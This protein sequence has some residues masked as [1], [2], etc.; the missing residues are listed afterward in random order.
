MDF[1]V[2]LPTYNNLDLARQ[3]ALSVLSQSSYSYELIIVDDSSKGDI[4]KFAHE[5]DDARVRYYHNASPLGAVSNWNHG[6]NM[7]TGDFVILLHHDER[8]SNP[9]HLEKIKELMAQGCDVAISPV[10]VFIGDERHTN[11]FQRERVRAFMI[12]HPLLLFC[13]NAIGPT[14]C[15]C[16]R[17]SSLAAFNEELHWLVDVQWYYELL[18]GRIVSLLGSDYPI[19]SRHGHG[20]QITNLINVYKTQAED[21]AV[22]RKLYKNNIRIRIALF[23]N[24]AMLQIRKLARK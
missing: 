13:A 17:K 21:S 5:L 2:V 10:S 24:K 12:R 18:K 22:I 3:A 11:I 15:V 6:L 19:V 20:D 16:V 9:S 14:A 8:F 1:S 4:E 23:V 7:A